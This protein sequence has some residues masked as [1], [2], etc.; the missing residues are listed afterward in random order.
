MR[1]LRF[2]P[3]AQKLWVLNAHE[4]EHHHHISYGRNSTIF[5][6]LFIHTI[7]YLLVKYLAGS[8]FFQFFSFRNLLDFQPADD[9]DSEWTCGSHPG[10]TDGNGVIDI[11]DILNVLGMFGM[12]V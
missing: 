9:G 3:S 7:S 11:G 5:T 2:S 12:T 10:D 4:V 6:V 8:S 1:R